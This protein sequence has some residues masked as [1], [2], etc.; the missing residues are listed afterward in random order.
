MEVGRKN[1][2]CKY[3]KCELSKPHQN[4]REALVNSSFEAHSRRQDPWLITYDFGLKNVLKL[5]VKAIDGN[6]SLWLLV[7]HAIREHTESI[8]KD[9]AFYFDS[10][11]SFSTW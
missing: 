1:R 8:F 5:T 3:V 11:I 4:S 6:L 7:A 9:L 10:A 2:G